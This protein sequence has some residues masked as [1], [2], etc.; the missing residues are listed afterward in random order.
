[1]PAGISGYTRDG[2]LKRSPEGQIVTSDGYPLVPDITIR[3]TRDRS[4]STRRARST[5]ISAT[6]EPEQLGASRSWASPTRGLEAIGSNLFLETAASGPP[7]VNDPGDGGARDAPA[8]L[9]R[10]KLGRPRPRGDRTDRGTARLRAEREGHHCRRPDAR[11]DDA[12]PMM[13]RTFIA[14]S[15]LAAG[16]SPAGAAFA[17]EALWPPER[18]A[19]EK[20]SVPPTAAR[21]T[22]TAGRAVRSC[23]GRHRHGRAPD[24]RTSGRPIM[25][26]DVGRRRWSAERRRSRLQSRL[27]DDPAEG[28]ALPMA[29]RATGCA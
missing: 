2:S 1:M 27:A 20:S 17:G 10:G 3:R 24:A 22:P 28:R 18:S 16:H 29:P 13:R 9:S 11:R 8:G 5:P 23:R 25:P 19:R 21:W 15:L 14:A 26:G 6:G 7:F 4:R 12:D